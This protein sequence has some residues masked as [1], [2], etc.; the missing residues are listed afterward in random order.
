MQVETQQPTWPH[1]MIKSDPADFHKWMA[2]S[3]TL[4]NRKLRNICLPASHDSDSW[5]FGT[6]IV[7]EPEYQWLPGI[8]SKLNTVAE[9]INKIPGIG[10]FIDPF[11]YMRH[12]L[13]Q[14]LTDLATTQDV[15]LAGQLAMGFRCLDLRVYDDGQSF[16]TH[17]GL[18]SQTTLAENFAAIATFLSSGT[19]IVYITC[20]HVL[21]PS[22]SSFRSDALRALVRQCFT[23]SQ[24]FLPQYDASGNVTNNPF[25]QTYTEITTQGGGSGGRA[26]IAFDDGNMYTDVCCFPKTYS[27][28]S[29]NGVVA[30]HGS[31][32]ESYGNMVDNQAQQFAERAGRPFAVSM[33][34]TPNATSSTAHVLFSLKNGLLMVAA[35][36]W[37]YAPVSIPLGL[38]AAGL[39]IGTW[40]ESWRTLRQLSE[41]VIANLYHD[42]ITRFQDP[43]KTTANHIAIIYVDFAQAVGPSFIYLAIQYSTLGAGEDAAVSGV[44]I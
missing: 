28:P 5:Q 44:P 30:G 35:A 14:A 8:Q 42:L 27:V 4:H 15:G 3:P 12:G 39:Y 32:T 1:G 26:I 17:H 11:E 33:T 37:Y 43:T 24:L 40:V 2:A 10:R 38:I 20:S 29:N 19:E 22:G 25:E 7:P 6:T 18:Q 21:A 36:A 41:P 9:A 16:W 23:D 13:V 31:D 34:L